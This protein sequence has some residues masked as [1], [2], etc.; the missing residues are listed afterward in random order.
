MSLRTIQTFLLILLSFI[1]AALSVSQAQANQAEYGGVVLPY[2]KSLP[3][4]VAADSLLYGY[5]QPLHLLMLKIN[6]HGSVEKFSSDQLATSRWH[7]SMLGYLGRIQFEPGRVNGRPSTFEL[8]AR[9]Y[10]DRADS[11]VALLLPSD[12][13]GRV[14]DYS[15]FTEALRLT[16]VILPGIV[17]FPW[18][19]AT[20]PAKDSNRV[21]RFVLAHVEF[22]AKGRAISIEKVS[23]NHPDFDDQFLSAINYGTFHA[24]QSLDSVPIRSGF[25]LATLFPTSQYPTKPWNRIRLDSLDLHDRMALRMLADT[26]GLMVPPTPLSRTDQTIGLP[27]PSLYRRATLAFKIR[28]N[29][30]GR[31]RV[32]IDAGNQ[33]GLYPLAMALEN[34][35]KFYPAVGFDGKTRA[36]DGWLIIRSNGESSVRI[37]FPWLLEPTLGGIPK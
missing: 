20:F 23:T 22:D 11:T 21:L 32:Y 37:S 29:E 18:Y 28:I 10:V 24:G 19:H 13:T 3:T 26:V 30:L 27:L 17:R 14:V 16:G 6:E 15:L 7:K 34:Q 12:T 33:S 35:L 5:L 9:L 25:V 8:P 4:P 31:S 36:F 2:A 1:A